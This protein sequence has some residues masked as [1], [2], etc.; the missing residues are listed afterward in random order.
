MPSSAGSDSD[1]GVACSS[2]P[3]AVV[4]IHAV[5]E[6]ALE[7]GDSSSSW[8]NCLANELAGFEDI[9]CGMAM[10][11]EVGGRGISSTLWS[12]GSEAGRGGSSRERGSSAASLLASV[13][14]ELE[15]LRVR[16]DDNKLMLGHGAHEGR[17]GEKETWLAVARS[18][19][20]LLKLA[21]ELSSHSP[22]A[23]ESGKEHER[24]RKNS[25]FRVRRVA[26]LGYEE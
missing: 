11:A 16:K 5:V 20:Y 15:N 21:C 4:G 18:I 6:G 1:M 7:A 26:R 23:A 22:S 3:W 8:R 13:G 14:C 25:I 24:A 2:P 12:T 19:L 10:G 9:S 17:E